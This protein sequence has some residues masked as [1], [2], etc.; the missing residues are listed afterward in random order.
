VKQVWNK[1]K[2]PGI[3]YREHV[4]RRLQN[5]QPDKYYTIRYKKKGKL[6]EEALGW[7]SEGWNAEKAFM[8]LAEIKSGARMGEGPQSLAEKRDLAEKHRND[9]AEAARAE[10]LASM[11]MATFF[12]DY[13]MPRAKKEKRSWLLDEQRIAKHINPFIGDIPM[14]AVQP[15]DVQSMLDRLG[16]TLAP[17]TLK[18]YMCIVRRAFNI[19]METNVDG[20]PLFDGRNPARGMRL[21]PV[22]NGRDR[23]LSVKEADMIIKAAKKLRDPDLHDLIVLSLNTGLR[24]GELVRLQWPDVDFE[25]DMLN[26]REEEKR[27]PGGKVPMNK[28]AKAVLKTRFAAKKESQL[29]FPPIFGA[30]TR[31]NIS[32]AFHNLIDDLKLNEGIAPDDRKRRI[33]FHTLRHTFASWLALGGTDIYRIKTLM[34]HNSIDMTL[35]YAHL[36]PDATREAVNNLRPKGFK[37]SS[38]LQCA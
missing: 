34:R 35:R 28:D 2:Y 27:K 8:V 9:A 6:T 25:H 13:Y 38:G 23:F 4:S 19:A 11:S 20:K 36:M 29:V 30:A 12:Q 5:G 16:E 14:R 31:S 22:R 26:V 17:A 10:V 18:Q 37:S 33:V 21:P 24:L 32:A 7:Q 1:T 3:R 15:S